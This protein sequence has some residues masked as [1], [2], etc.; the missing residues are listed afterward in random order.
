MQREKKIRALNTLREHISSWSALGTYMSQAQ[1]STMRTELT[2]LLD[3]LVACTSDVDAASSKTRY[4][5]EERYP[6][7]ISRAVIKH[8]K[9][10]RPVK[11]DRTAYADPSSSEFLQ[12]LTD[13]ASFE[14]FRSPA[15]A[16][17]KCYQLSH[18]I[19]VY[20]P[21]CIQL[22]S[23]CVELLLALRSICGSMGEANFAMALSEAKLVIGDVSKRIHLWSTWTRAKALILLSEIRQG[24][25][26]LNRDLVHFATW[27]DIFS[28][29]NTLRKQ[30]TIDGMTGKTRA[31]IIE[32]L[33]ELLNSTSDTSYIAHQPERIVM[34]HMLGLQEAIHATVTRSNERQILEA[35]LLTIHRQTGL[36]PPIADLTGEV[37][38]AKQFSVDLGECGDI[39]LGKWL[40]EED[41]ALTRTRTQGAGWGSLIHQ[42]LVQR[43]DVWRRLRHRNIVRFYGIAMLDN[44]I[45]MISKWMDRDVLTYLAREPDL[46]R[47]KI[48]NEIAHGVEFLHKH[49]VVHGDLR[50]ANIMVSSDG[51][52]C[53]T[54][55]GLSDILG[56]KQPPITN[57]NVGSIRCH[58][59]MELWHVRPRNFHRPTSFL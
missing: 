13:L 42:L 43:L 33:Q 49:G 29:M 11:T 10:S 5:S 35:R 6:V 30:Q 40:S 21:A 8:R 19:K 20:K 41:V 23:R 39:Y 34:D 15:R 24:L 58:R 28:T 7:P 1:L 53:I 57:D 45:Y 46:D 3:A 50:G 27:F 17:L 52:P 36:L 4:P 59:R 12:D 32:T 9:A 56:N 25:A 51:V 47:L 18:I 2:R 48:L 14:E 37:R 54:Y 55:F 31:R 16:L 22:L 44:Q 26:S 38:I